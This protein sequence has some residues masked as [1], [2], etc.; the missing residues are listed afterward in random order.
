M[1]KALRDMNYSITSRSF[2]ENIIGFETK[3]PTDNGYFYRGI[4]F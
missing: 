1:I 4:K 2:L 3:A